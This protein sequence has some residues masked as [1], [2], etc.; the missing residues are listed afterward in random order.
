MKYFVND[1]PDIKKNLEIAAASKY[2]NSEKEF[3]SIISKLTKNFCTYIW[4][5]NRYLILFGEMAKLS[6]DNPDKIY[7][8]WLGV[9]GCRR[10]VYY[11]VKNC[12]WN[13]SAH[14]LPFKLS[15]QDKVI[16]MRHADGKKYLHFITSRSHKQ[17][18]FGE[19]RLKQ[20]LWK[21]IRLVWIGYYKNDLIKQ[22]C[23][24]KF[25]IVTNFI[26]SLYGNNQ[27]ETCMFSQL[28][29]DIVKHIVSFLNQDVF[30]YF[31]E[32]IEQEF[33]KFPIK[34]F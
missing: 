2:E 27:Q 3:E 25:M 24:K 17:L 9:Y 8:P 28:P 20:Q 4:Y 33:F 11:D 5:K 34:I 1:E 22:K 29:N 15:P 30:L 26:T 14:I 31:D 19:M 16:L 12:I 23:N 32:K 6:N 7:Y 21:I 18:E 10:I 13:K